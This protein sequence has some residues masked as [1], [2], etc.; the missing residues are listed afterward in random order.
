MVGTDVT[1]VAPCSPIAH[2]DR[3]RGRRPIIFVSCRPATPLLTRCQWRVKGTPRL[4]MRA[5]VSTRAA[6]RQSGLVRAGRHAAL[7]A[8][9]YQPSATCV[10]V[11]P[12]T[13]QRALLPS[14][15]GATCGQTACCRRSANRTSRTAGCNRS[16]R[17]CDIKTGRLSAAQCTVMQALAHCEASSC[18]TC[19]CETSRPAALKSRQICW[20]M[21]PSDSRGQTTVN[22]ELARRATAGTVARST[23]A[24]RRNKSKMRMMT[25][26]RADAARDT[27]HRQPAARMARRHY[28]MRWTAAGPR[29]RTSGNSGVR[30][31][32]MRGCAGGAN[33][34]I[35]CGER[36]SR[37]GHMVRRRSA[38]ASLLLHNPRHHAG[39]LGVRPAVGI[40]QACEAADA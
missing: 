3:C 22:R 5:G 31:V 34:A 28:A 36:R 9:G 10:K 17:A 25:P 30:N 20:R 38:D 15:P 33:A 16:A 14:A 32:G 23:P 7:R 4:L 12:T 19:I 8:R 29:G 27:V 40:V 39:G 6:R 35:R 13:H 37:R 26:S 11:G 18:S 24:R 21:A 2:S 1:Q